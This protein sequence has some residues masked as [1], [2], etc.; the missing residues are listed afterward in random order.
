MP[1]LPSNIIVEN[2]SKTKDINDLED[3]VKQEWIESL[4]RDIQD[5]EDIEM[6]VKP[7]NKMHGTSKPINK[8]TIK[9]ELLKA[10]R[11]KGGKKSLFCDRCTFAARRNSDLEQHIRQHH[12]KIKLAC[13]QCMYKTFYTHILRSHIQNVHV[14][15]PLSCTGFSSGWSL[16]RTIGVFLPIS[17]IRDS[18]QVLACQG[19]TLVVIVTSEMMIRFTFTS[20]YI[21][22]IC[23]PIL[24]SVLPPGSLG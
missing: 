15:I 8:E 6:K 2:I 24:V 20:W 14:G 4:N 18:A 12:D 10:K 1:I 11:N 21:F 16:F 19:V 3:L 9:G 7:G 23:Y 5:I 22:I 17:Q 13:D